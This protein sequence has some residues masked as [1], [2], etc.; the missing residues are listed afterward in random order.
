MTFEADLRRFARNAGDKGDALTRKL[1]LE[2]TKR[3]VMRTPVD[4][5]RL[6]ANWQATLNIPAA[7]E[8]TLTD[9][10]GT[11]TISKASAV[12]QRAPGNVFWLVNNLPYAQV[13]EYGL[14]GT[15]DGATNKTTRDGYS[16][17]APYGMVRVTLDEIKLSI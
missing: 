10:S 15:G 7:G 2:V 4:T 12:A 8:I 6:R 5:G 16:V 17:Q 13:A 3:V 1:C 11:S 9:P 14:W